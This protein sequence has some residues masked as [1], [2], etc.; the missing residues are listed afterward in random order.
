[1]R[2]AGSPPSLVGEEAEAHFEAALA[3]N[4]RNRN[5]LWAAHAQFELA[6]ILMRRGGEAR[7]RGERCSEAVRRQADASDFVRLKRKLDV[8][9]AGRGGRGGGPARRCRSHAGRRGAFAVCRRRCRRRR[10]RSIGRLCRLSRAQPRCLA[11]VDGAVAILFSDL[12]DSTSLY[13]QLG[14]QRAVDLV[15][16]HNDMFR[17]EV[18]AHR[19]HEVKSLGD[20]FMIVFSSAQRAALCAMAVQRAFKAYS[21]S[22]PDAPMRVRIGLHVGRRSTSPWICSAGRW[23]WPR[24]SRAS[25]AAVRSSLRRRCAIFSPRGAMCALRPWASRQLKGFSAPYEL[26]EVGW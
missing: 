11:S 17:R 25:P 12:E 18:A 23:S 21:E 4:R 15:R 22:H 19:G 20:G 9:C 26:F 13:D 1:M 7:E 16:M 2:S 6:R 14:D 24:A 8:P 10:A 5:P 3:A